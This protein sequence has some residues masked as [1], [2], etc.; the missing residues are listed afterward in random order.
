[1]IVNVTPRQ[2]AH[3]REVAGDGILRATME[4]D[5]RPTGSGTW[6]DVTAPYLAWEIV[7]RR[8]EEAYLTPSLA[9]TKKTPDAAMRLLQHIA[10]AQN[11]MLRHP[12]LR[13][14]AMIGMQ[15][16]W[17]P[18]WIMKTG[19]VSPVPVLDGEFTVIGPRWA[20]NQNGTRVTRWAPDGVWPRGHWL[21]SESAHTDLLGEE[22]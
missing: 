11:T 18:L 13:G 21:T 17:F 9:M 16:G 2:F 19:Q 7:Q 1:M 10:K 8:L 14:A 6:F 3:V 22:S 5:H 12:A 20:T 15:A 4:R